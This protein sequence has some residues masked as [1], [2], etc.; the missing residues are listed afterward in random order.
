MNHPLV[1]IPSMILNVSW[2]FIVAHFIMSWLIAFNVLNL[3][4]QMVGQIWQSLNRL[5][6][7][8]YRPLRQYLP[9]LG[10]LD[11]VP[12]AALIIIAALQYILD[13]YGA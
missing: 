3:H 9:N 4:Q 13:Y 8:L 2:F 6:D 1:A 10:G 11:L 12:L 5:L 7:P